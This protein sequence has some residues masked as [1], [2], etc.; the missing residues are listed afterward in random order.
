MTCEKY[1]RS[2]IK[3]ILQSCNQRGGGGQNTAMTPKSKKKRLCTLETH[4]FFHLATDFVV[5]LFGQRSNLTFWGWGETQSV[6]SHF[7]SSSYSPPP[8][9]LPSHTHSH[10]NVFSSLQHLDFSLFFLFFLDFS[11]TDRVSQDLDFQ[12]DILLC[13]QHS[14]SWSP[15]L[16]LTC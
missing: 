15:D 12:L 16:I 4:D 6:S 13:L 1:L 8:P 10:F 3:I 5:E 9:P 11:S 7:S 2:F 14:S